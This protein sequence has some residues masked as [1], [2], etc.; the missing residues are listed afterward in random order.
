M[1]PHPEV[2]YM[3]Q[4]HKTPFLPHLI[5][6]TLYNPVPFLLGYQNSLIL[7]LLMQTTFPLQHLTRE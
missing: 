3:T 7:F 1:R 2:F 5:F 6:N 4:T